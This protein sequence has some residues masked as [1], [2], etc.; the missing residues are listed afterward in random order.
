MRY[1]AN[2]L[3]V[4][5]VP[6]LPFLPDG[7]TLFCQLSIFPLIRQILASEHIDVVHGHLGSSITVNMCM[8]LAQTLGIKTVITEHVHFL[9]NDPMGIH[10]NK[11]LKWALSDVDAAICVSH[12][13]KENF[14][15][16]AKMNPNICFTIPNAVDTSKYQPNPSLRSP[17]HTINI[18]CLSRLMTER[19]VDLLLE[20]IPKV[21]ATHSSAYFIIGGDGEKVFELERLVDG[22]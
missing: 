14:T 8:I 2:G 7:N 9:Y 6:L 22:L 16:R 11:F 12:A 3:K 19:G 15:L 21:I 20:I 13:C 17:A 10:F 4:Y 1:L 5:Y 18:V